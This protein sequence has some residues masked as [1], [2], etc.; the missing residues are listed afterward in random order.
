MCTQAAQ[1]LLL[2]A[3]AAHAVQWCRQ[4][5]HRASL[6]WSRKCP[7]HVH[8]TAL[9]RAP[10]L[11]NS[12]D[13]E[14]EGALCLPLP[15]NQQ[16]QLLQRQGQE[17]ESALCLPFPPKRQQ[18]QMQCPQQRTGPLHKEEEHKQGQQHRH[19]HQQRFTGTDPGKQAA[20]PALSSL[21]HD[22]PVRVK[23]EDIPQKGVTK[24][25]LARTSSFAHQQRSAAT[26]LP[27]PLR[28][29]S[30]VFVHTRQRRQQDQPQHRP[31]AI[32]PH[33]TATAS[34]GL[35]ESCSKLPRAPLETHT[36]SSTSLGAPASPN[37]TPGGGGGGGGGDS[38]PSTAG[39]THAPNNPS[40]TPHLTPPPPASSPSN[41]QPLRFSL[42]PLT[43]IPLPPPTRSTSPTL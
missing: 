20:T 5:A 12:E 29:T 24:A 22:G 16:Q 33:V 17:E 9:A 26:A 38:T 19:P 30:P 13:E 25:T 35:R 2:A 15:P 27:A 34:V 31:L 41:L 10:G 21:L 8:S 43:A 6:A 7:K 18:R 23:C 3:P 40:A 4:W 1:S 32:D 14:D 36:S 42:S 28:S 37:P 39:H 11:G